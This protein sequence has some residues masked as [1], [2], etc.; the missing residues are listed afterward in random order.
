MAL[1]SLIL[2]IISL[3]RSAGISQAANAL[4]GLT[5]QFGSLSGQIGAAAASFSAFQALAG[6]RQFTVD[7][8]NATARFERNLLGLNQVF[9][10]LQPRLV[11]F[12]REV[13]NYGLSQG[14]A[15]QASVFL[16]SVLKQYGF[17]TDETAFQTERLVKLSQDLATTY[18][19]DVSEALLAV[20]ALFRGEYD[21]IEKFGVAMKQN[22]VNARLAAQGLNDLEGEA[23]ANAQAIARLE[24][25]FE[26]AGDSLGAFERASNTLYGSQQKLNAVLGNLQLAAGA[27]LQ[28]PLANINNIFSEILQ[29]AGPGLTQIFEALAQSV[30]TFAPLIKELGTF[31]FGLLQPLQQVINILNGLLAPVI[32]FVL[33]PGFQVLNGVLNVFNS[34]LDSVGAQLRL[35]ELN[36]KR[37]AAL[38]EGEQGFYGLLG[39]F[40]NLKIEAQPLIMALNWLTKEFEAAGDAARAAAGDFDAFESSDRQASAAG[41]RSA[42]NARASKDSFEELNKALRGAA[43][44]AKDAEGKLG[45]LAGVFQRID[46]AI[47]KSEAQQ[48]LE[49]LGFSAAFIEEVLT[50]PNWEQIFK[51]ISYYASLAAIEVKKVFDGTGES[52]R[53][54]GTLE[55]LKQQTLD[56]INKLFGEDT[57]KTGAKTT[58]DFFQGLNEEVAKQKAAARLK[59]M[60]ASEGLIQAILGADEW[61]KTYKRILADGV[62]GLEKLQ[63]QFNKTAAG[64]EEMANAAKEYQEEQD[65][66]IEAGRKAFEDSIKELVKK[67]EDAQKAFEKAQ[68]AAAEFRKTLS[69]FGQIEILPNIEIELGRFEEAI[70]SSI[71]KVRSDLKQIFRQELILESDFNIISEFVATEEAAL[72]NIA[73][74]R[75]AMAKKLSLSEA[76]IGEYQKALTGALQLT[77][78]FSKLK[79]ETEKR[80]VTEVQ[81]GV[82]TLGRALR[83]FE[84]QVTR[85]YEEPIQQIQNKTEGLLQ[86]FRD[87]AD[88]ARTFAENLR[89][90]KALGLDPMLFNQL[91]QAGA[92]AGGETAQ[93]IVDGGSEAVNELNG[94][95]SELNKLG[96]ELGMD[97]G[98]TMYE[99]GKDMTFGLLE[100]IKSE[101]ERL[102]A[103]ARSMAEAFSREFQSKLSIA[104]DAKEKAMEDAANLAKAAVPDIKQVDLAALGKITTLIANTEKWLT[105]NLSV[106]ERIRSEDI[107][108]IYRGLERD[109]L[110]MR[111]IDLS[112]IRAG[113]SVEELQ[114]AARLAGG[115]NVTNF[116]LETYANTREQGA[117]AGE[118]IVDAL[119]AFQRA[120]G[121]IGGFTYQVAV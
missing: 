72:R 99:A 5:G 105:R 27:P 16:G 23:L 44:G 104:V 75:D 64:I 81:R 49:N 30:D 87:M 2:P 109:I 98:M 91:V 68:E 34:L 78:L 67:A 83:E 93:A 28:E 111:P 40:Q 108:E 117:K 51:N 43:T 41:R 48:E 102:L 29:N 4:R 25:L 13:E 90:L 31:L 54:A 89:R 79:G 84:V 59:G 7:S 11:S 1:Q 114:T 103:L 63:N 19:Y 52:A 100:G 26:R 120:N 70:V 6:A 110:A 94:I 3:F 33:V 12:T 62:P 20:T 92:E 73:K 21:P 14:Q 112:G 36:F 58:Q 71:E 46:E 86:G 106:F 119:T 115:T 97:V 107:L 24:M 74:Q 121:Q 50:R 56:R 80:T 82:I 32:N 15:A 65:R 61:E 95:F 39:Q 53:F 88:K 76:L 45:G 57:K 69:E 42:A 77:S 37:V 35:F 22:E 101:Q 55:N 96:A 10:E 85:S 38:V 118:E 116:Y 47:D 17:T 66:F 18:G 9:E 60:G 113:M 8:V